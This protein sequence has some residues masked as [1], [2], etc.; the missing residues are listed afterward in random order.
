MGSATPSVESWHYMHTKRFTQLSLC[1]RVAGGDMPEVEITSLQNTAGVIT[2]V[3]Q[4][5]MKETLQQN[6]QILLLINRRGFSRMFLCVQCGQSISCPHCSVPLVLH[7]KTEV[8]KLQCHHCGYHT[9]LP[10]SC[11]SCGYTAL[12]IRGWGTQRVEKEVQFL[13]PH[14]RVGRFDS[15]IATDKKKSHEVLSQFFNR[16]ISILVGTQM[17]AKGINIPH[18]QLVGV[19]CVDAMLSLP[20]F[21]AP[22]RTLGLLTQVSGRAGR[23]FK[24]G[25]VVIQTYMPNNPLLQSLAQH[26]QDLFY[27]SELQR[28]AQF[29]FPPFSRILRLVFR[30]VRQKSVLDLAEAFSHIVQNTIKTR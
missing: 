15:D 6:N 4:Q 7:K 20:D 28:R 21:R 12:S 18:L 9:S 23:F 10:S 29:L 27:T 24:H 11:P 17:M 16:T 26:S 30:G 19:I 1:S 2:P 14:H 5:R 22:E 8:M 25:K 13:F 3:L